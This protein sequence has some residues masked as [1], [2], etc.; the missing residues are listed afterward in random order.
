V[1]I[2]YALSNNY[3]SKIQADRFIS[4]LD[5]GKF[6]LK[7]SAYR[8]FLPETGCDWTLD[9][10]L[11][12]E[13]SNQYLLQNNKYL[14]IYLDQ[15]KSFNPDLI[16]SDLEFYTS[17]VA[18]LL[19]KELW[20]VSNKLHNFAIDQLFKYNI[21]IFKY[22]KGLYDNVH[23]HQKLNEIIASASK[24]Y[25]Y[26]HF[27]DVD[28]RIELKK[29]FDWIRPY[30]YTYKKSEAHRHGYVG[31]SANYSI[32]NFISDKKDSVL[33]SSNS[34][35]YENIICKPYS[36]IEEYS[37]NLASCDYYVCNGSA[38]FLADAFYNQR[39]FYL[40]KDFSCIDNIFNY[41]L[42]YYIYK[43]L[44]D[45]DGSISPLEI[46]MN[47][48]VNYLHENILNFQEAMRKQ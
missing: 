13:K 34:E 27:C 41:H 38:S 7:V 28:E 36:N 17:Y 29:G 45:Q 39:R 9:P 30:H 5:S 48:N 26:S 37:C 3:N 40:V 8:N 24:N 21:N 4:H 23:Y 15:V 25:L 2:L 18:L 31:V 43:F 12:P 33:F 42:Y 46:N 16:I 20:H 35:Q 10:L 1:N 32:V 14:D 19:G 6:T 44:I 22:Y 11:I 47:D